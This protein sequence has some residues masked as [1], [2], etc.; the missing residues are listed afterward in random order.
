MKKAAERYDGDG[1]EDAPGSPKIDVIQIGNEVDGGPFW[2]DTPPHYA[3]LLKKSYQAIKQVA[4]DMKV[5]IAGV[6][7]PEGFY[8]YYRPVFKELEK[9]KDKK[10][11]ERYFDV[12]DFH[13]S[14][15]FRGDYK[16]IELPEKTYEMR[17]FISDVKSDLKEMGYGDVLFY[18]TEMSDYSGRPNMNRAMKYPY[19]SE[20]YQ[21]A[22]LVK[23]YVYSLAC[24][25][26][27]IYWV[28]LQEFNGFGGMFD[29]Y[30]DNVGLVKNPSPGKPACKKLA[31]YTYKKMTEVL[32]G[33]DWRSIQKVRESG[34]IHIYRFSKNG[35]SIW[36]AWNDTKTKQQ[37]NISGIAAKNVRI[38]RSVPAAKAGRAVTDYTKA[39]EIKTLPAKDGME[40]LSPGS[41]P[42]FVE[43]E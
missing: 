15:Q 10:P 32:A 31:Y 27:K 16:A 14:G 35:K 8:R 5:A 30:F 36:V 21:A 2:D 9:I 13:W 33:S 37:V 18:I 40:N 6:A 28:T 4:P 23:R 34:G 7:T 12:F 11:G 39:F 22:S 41:I 24:G 1:I 26:D 19:H 43:E 20:Q 17:D 3:L 25:V 29:G 42:I 38:T